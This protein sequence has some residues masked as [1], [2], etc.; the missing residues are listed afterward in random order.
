MLIDDST[1]LTKY[2]DR[3]ADSGVVIKKEELSNC[4]KNLYNCTKITKYRNFQ[5]RLLLNKIF[6]NVDYY[7]WGLQLS[8]DCNFGCNTEETITH[9]LYRCDKI[10][11]IQQK[12]RDM[13]IT[14]EVNYVLDEKSFITNQI[15]EQ[16]T[17][18]IQFICQ[19]AKQFI[20]RCKCSN[21]APQLRGWLNEISDI[22]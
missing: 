4:F 2:I 22:Y 20:Y 11:D 5:Y 6:T 19:H 17:H 18:I 7:N 16:S 10:S 1:L 14:A 13:C 8:A 12:I 15:T 3:W 21:K 9:L